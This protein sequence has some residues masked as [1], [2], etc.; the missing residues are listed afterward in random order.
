MSKRIHFFC[1]VGLKVSVGHLINNCGLHPNL[2]PEVTIIGDRPHIILKAKEKIEPGDELH[3]D[4]G[5][6]VYFLAK[7]FFFFA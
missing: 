7:Y 3:F 6:L 1:L 5:N 2:R 4:Y